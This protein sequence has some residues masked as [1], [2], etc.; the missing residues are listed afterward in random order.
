MALGWAPT[1]VVMVTA[2]G[3]LNG[4]AILTAQRTGEDGRS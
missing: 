2:M 1:A 3:L 4:V